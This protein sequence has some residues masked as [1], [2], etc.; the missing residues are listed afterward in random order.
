VTLADDASPERLEAATRALAD[1]RAEITVD[2][3]HLMQEQLDRSWTS[4]ADAEL[5]VG[6]TIRNRGAALL[7][8]ELTTTRERDPEAR[9]FENREWSA[10]DQSELGRGIE[11]IEKPFVITAR[12]DREIVGVARGWTSGGIGYLS[13][14]MVAA[15]HR[16]EGIGSHL[17]A[18]FTSLGAERRC[19]RLALRTFA[20]RAAHGFYKAHGWVDEARFEPWVFGRAFVQLRRDLT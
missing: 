10:F 19:R 17:L 1:F 6:P 16:G 2:R 15:E 7:Q 8:L 5:G 18:A 3:V 14:L 11:W 20:D 13:A 4:I 9:A 12:R